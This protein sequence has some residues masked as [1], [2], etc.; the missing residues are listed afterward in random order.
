MRPPAADRVG[1]AVLPGGLALAWSDELLYAAGL[2]PDQLAAVVAAH[3]HDAYQGLTP[4]R[5]SRDAG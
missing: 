4:L 5:L 1:V 3:W 2:A